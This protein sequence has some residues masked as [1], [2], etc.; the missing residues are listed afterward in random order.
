M[1]ESPRL[2]CQVLCMARTQAYGPVTDH[3][4]DA[5]FTILAG[6]AVF[7]VN[8]SRKRLSQWATVL[9]PAG[10]EVAVR[11]ASVDPLVLMLT[12]APPPGPWDR[13]A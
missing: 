5:I 6:E 9:V 8:G 12:V 7:M 3:D 2:W 11:N 13:P 1:F 10:A 4:S